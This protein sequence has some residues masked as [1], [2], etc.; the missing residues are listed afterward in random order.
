RDD[1]SPTPLT[2]QP[3]LG[4]VLAQSR[5]FDEVPPGRTLMAARPADPDPPPPAASPVDSRAPRQLGRW[6]LRAQCADVS[7]ISVDR[8]TLLQSL[9]PPMRDCDCNTIPPQVVEDRWQSAANPLHRT[10]RVR[11]Q[12]GDLQA[13][14]TS[15]P[16]VAEEHLNLRSTFRA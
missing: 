7:G 5:R 11:Y 13:E 4:T 6:S 2:G 8:T 15:D 9:R 10:L 1:G 12:G 16:K 3:V 14:G